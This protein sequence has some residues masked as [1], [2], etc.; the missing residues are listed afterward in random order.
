MNRFISYTF[1]VQNDFAYIKIILNN[2]ECE[3]YS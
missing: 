2:K 3:A 1:I